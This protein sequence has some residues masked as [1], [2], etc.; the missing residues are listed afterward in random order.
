[1]ITTKVLQLPKVD[2]RS[3]LLALLLLLLS[4][5]MVVSFNS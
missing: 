5:F 3:S 1:M 4:Y 2:L